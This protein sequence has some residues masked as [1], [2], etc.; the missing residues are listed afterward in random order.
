MDF[1]IY[2]PE[3][4][5]GRMYAGPGSGPMLAAAQAWAALADELWASAGAYQSIVSELTTGL[6][7]GPSAA[8]MTAAAAIHVEWLSGTAALA[9]RTAT[10]ATAAVVAYETAF[11]MTVPPPMIAANRSLRAVLVATNF[12]GQNTSAIAAAEAQY[13][14]MW[15]QDAVA[16]YDYGSSSSAATALAPWAS[17]RQNTDPGAAAGQA[18][19]VS[20]A[21]SAPIG[22]TQ[23][24]LARIAQAFSGVPARLQSLAVP[25]DSTSSTGSLDVLSDLISIFLGTPSDVVGL[26][27]SLP[28]GILGGPVDLPFNIIGTGTGF[29]T[30]DIVSGWGGEESRPGPGETPGEPPTVSAGVGS[31]DRVGALAVP[32]AWTNAAPEIRPLA[33]ACPVTDIDPVAPLEADSS[34]TLSDLGLAGMT[35]RAMAGPSSSG[36]VA[37]STDVRVPPRAG[38]PAVVGDASNVQPRIVVTGVAA[39]IRELAKLRDEGRLTE[40]DYTELKNRLLGRS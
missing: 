18:A 33:L 39:R 19:A 5:S 9:E 11:A 22:N 32:S 4:N 30:D 8:S 16:M 31:S 38:R 7:T 24:I 21:T 12:F 10:Q 27:G 36:A 26:G 17:P 34:A 20:K 3:I 40:A 35:G 14:E 29:H 1:G 23:D 13:A 25:G 37:A 6:W 28:L 2:P 15:A